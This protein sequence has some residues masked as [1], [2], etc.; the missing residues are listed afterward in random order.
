MAEIKKNNLLLL[1]MQT[2]LLQLLEGD[3]LMQGTPKNISSPWQRWHES[4][5]RQDFK[6][7]ENQ[8]RILTGMKVATRALEMAV[9]YA[10]QEQLNHP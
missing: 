9:S 1:C 3:G 5:A 4:F 8:N 7:E 6:A 10:L 2:A